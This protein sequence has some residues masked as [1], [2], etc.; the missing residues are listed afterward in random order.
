M[1][2]LLAASAFAA[3]TVSASLNGLELEIEKGTG[4]IVSLSVPGQGKILDARSEAASILDLAYP[5]PEFEPLRLA[6]R[7]SKDAEIR[8]TDKEVTIHW[9]RLGAS[10]DYLQP[11]G[12]V[13][14]TVT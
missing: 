12:S 6:S 4:S 10:R 1:V 5:I 7:Y 14:A 2:L 11:E 8:V 9:E 3:D 13:R